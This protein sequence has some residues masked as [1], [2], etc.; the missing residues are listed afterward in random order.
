MLLSNAPTNPTVNLLRPAPAQPNRCGRVARCRCLRPSLPLQ[1]TAAGLVILLH[2]WLLIWSLQQSVRAPQ[3][4]DLP[5]AVTLIIEPITTPPPHSVAQ[6]S[7]PM[8]PQ[9]FETA[10][11]PT[12]AEP[13]ATPP[14]ESAVL[15]RLLRLPRHLHAKAIP[16]LPRRRG[17]MLVQQPATVATVERPISLPSL[18]VPAMPTRPMPADGDT[19]LV[20]LELAIDRSV[21]A[22][23]IMPGAA[24]RLHLEGRV[25]VRFSYVD[26]TAGGAT[27][28]K[29]AQY[30]LLDDAALQAVRVAVYPAAPDYLQG[31]RLE[32]LVWINFNLMPV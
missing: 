9:V 30:R 26:G 23:A 20:N 18:A 7:A 4:T 11:Q 22:A 3:A 2:G 10:L 31:R 13:H 25:L 12:P 16:M 32:L 14:Q 6:A 27:V 21:R 28:I 19:A 24:K 1:V 15:L 29:S 5:M 17:R 8:A